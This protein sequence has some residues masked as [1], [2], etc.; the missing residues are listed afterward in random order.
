[1][2]KAK[3]AAQSVLL[4]ISFTILSKVFGFFREALI[5]ARFGSGIE[6]DTYFIAQSANRLFTA[7]ITS[8]LATTAIPI[9]SR[10][11]ALEG[12]K[13]K[14]EHTSNLLSI[15]LIVAVIISLLAWI[16]APFIMKIFAYGFDHDQFTFA[17]FM[18]RLG[19]P[20]ILFAALTGVF[21]GY[22]Q[23]EN[24][25]FA[26]SSAGILQNILFITFLIFFAKTL[27]IKGL[28]VTSVLGIGSQLLVLVFGSK[29][30]GFRYRFVIDFKDKYIKQILVLIPPILLSVAIGDINAMIDK[31]MASTLVK[32]SISALNYG[33][34]LN[35]LASSIFISAIITVLYPMLSMGA[36]ENDLASVKRTTTQGINLILIITVPATV[37]MLILAKPI[38]HIAYERGVFD[39]TATQMTVGALV[40]YTF[41]L[42]SSSV[43]GLLVRVFYSL[44]DTKT[45]L[46]NSGIAVAIN[47]LMNFILI[48]PLAHRGLAL[49]TSLSSISTTI[50]LTF[51]LRRKIGSL[52]LSN[53][54]L[55]G[56]KSLLASVPMAM[57]VVIIFKQTTKIFSPSF[58][59]ELLALV[60]P[61]ACGVIIYF[62]ILYLLRV[63]ELGWALTQVKR[64]INRK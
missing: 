35:A 32:G 9:L 20:A 26:S 51:L 6:T 46:I 8:T 10:I 16:L 36:A 43:N 18:M 53:S 24:R 39:A 5:A 38:V 37:G 56:F 22:L 42:V 31:A 59:G 40:F 29:V 61:V 1:M 41:S 47:V 34:V 50:V 17:V 28:M 13:A 23:S 12:K 27:G 2:S 62:L 48:G 55:C 4:I 64:R 52:N 63:D 45:P 58:L 21:N 54:L 57:L 15:T 30:A 60:I 7:I 19:L 49:A 14:D 44:R 3:R 25:F 11:M 33:S